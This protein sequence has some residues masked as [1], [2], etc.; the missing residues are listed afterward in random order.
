MVHVNYIQYYILIQKIRSISLKQ[1]Q[2]SL[3]CLF[4]VQCQQ[5]WLPFRKHGNL[6]AKWSRR[7][8]LISLRYQLSLATSIYGLPKRFCETFYIFL[9]HELF[10]VT[11]A[12]GIISVCMA[13][14][15]VS[16]LLL[17]YFSWWSRV[18]ITVIKPSF[19][20]NGV[21]S[22]QKVMINRAMKLHCLF[23]I[24]DADYMS[25]FSVNYLCEI[26]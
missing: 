14:F 21:F 17:Y 18:R 7:I 8:P 15:K 6:Y 23:S 9:G 13:T 10:W 25:Y 12:S 2:T 19:E 20:S 4:L 3:K 26:C 22:Q 16:K 1:L 11:G 5:T 24:S